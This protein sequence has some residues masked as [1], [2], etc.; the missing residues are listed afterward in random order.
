MLRG[1]L[2]FNICLLSLCVFSFY[3]K[4]QAQSSEAIIAQREA[5][6]RAELDQV[7]AEIE[8]QKSVLSQKQAEGASIERDLAILDAQISE[9]KLKIRAREIA[10]AGLGKDINQKTQHIGVLGEKVD[11]SKSSLKQLIKKTYQ[12][13]DYSLAEVVLSN[14]NLSSFFQ[15]MDSYFFINQALNSSLDN[16]KEAK[17]NT[18]LERTTLDK[19]RLQEIDA[20]VSI[21][22]EK[23]IIEKAEAEKKRLL[24]LSKQEQQGY[25]NEIRTRE[26]K[27]AAIRSALFNLRDSAAI[28]FEKALEYATYASQK[29]GVRAAF[30]LGILTQESD[31]GKNIGTCNRPGDPINKHWTNIMPGPEDKA[32]KRSSRD[33]QTIFV[34]IVTALGMSPEG[35]PLSC[36]I[37]NGWGGAM[38]PSQFIPTTWK[39]YS[40]RIANAIGVPTASPWNAQHAIMAT[41]IYVSDLGAGGGGYSAERTAALKYY[42]GGNWNK[43]QNAFY[44]NQVMQKTQNIQ[45]NM[46]NILQGV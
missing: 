14:K 15:D 25:Q 31:L 20:K 10:I 6:L 18:E 27:A 11:L 22:A 33:D 36:P 12:L 19:K 29:T 13:D 44:G 1:F 4:T 41:A 17:V 32:A 2:I 37:G 21:E 8:I 35:T 7:M 39:A 38:G 30:I 43:P 28:P 24:N 23:R 46:I 40:T 16:L 3:H 9:S 26:Q 5:Q 42:A 45:E 34:E